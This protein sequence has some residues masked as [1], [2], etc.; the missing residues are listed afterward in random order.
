M[1]LAHRMT[2]LGTETAFSVSAEANAHRQA[3]HRVFPFHLGDINIPTPENVMEAAIRAMKGG[4]TGYCSNLGIPELREALAEDVNRSHATHY[5][6]ENVVIEPGGKPVIGKFLLALMNPGDQVLYP[7]PGYP[8]YESQIEFHGGVAV[9]Y[10]YREGDGVFELDLDGLER[11]LTDKTRILILNDLQN[12]MGAE[13]SA[14][15]RERLAEIVRRH[16]LI[17]LLD[18]A[19][20]DIRYEGRSQSLV[21]LAGMEERC[22]LLYT[23]SKKFAMTGWRL[24]AAIGPRPVAEAI[25]KL[26]VNDESCSNHFIQYGA[27]EG[28]RGDQSGPRRILEELKKRRDLCV[29]LLNGIPGV[30]CF[31]PRATFYL[32]PNVTEAMART[33]LTQYEEFRKTVLRET[34]VSFCSR[35]HFGRPLPGEVQKYIRFA[36]SGIDLPDIEEGLRLLKGFVTS[37]APPKRTAPLASTAAR[38]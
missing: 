38:G 13:A 14:H 21:S 25:G 9:P 5:T 23:F 30:R 4:K 34:G 11:A 8:I 32:F 18:E 20:F 3:G 10:S 7:N 17:V 6:L 28:L 15:E 33:G 24:G 2:R 36:Y 1:Q 29:D 31:R 19:Y 26:N 16:H 27:L 37:S 22:V 12:P 35:L